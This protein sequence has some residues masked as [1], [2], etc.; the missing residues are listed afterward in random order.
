MTENFPDFTDC[1]RQA[2]RHLFTAERLSALLPV[3]LMLPVCL[4]LAACGDKPEKPAPPR[5]VRT[6]TV[7][8][9]SSAGAF[10]QT[11][12][13]RPHDEVTL[14]F[15]LDGRLL[16]RSVDVGDHVAAGQVLGSLENS[17]SQ[18][19]LDSARADLD[20][21]RAAEQLA[22]LNLRRMS[23]LIS[24]GAIARVQ[25]DTARSDWQAAT[26][27]R[28]SSEAALNT[29]RENLSW[30][31]LVAPAGGVVTQVSAEP[32]Q[33]VSAGQTVVTLAV[34]SG[35]DAVID[36]ADPQAFSHPAGGFRVSLLAAPSVSVTGTLRDISPQ[37]DAQTRTWRVRV[38]L[39]N[40]PTAMA[41][42]ASVQVGLAGTGPAVM[43]LP[44]S[45]LTRAQGRPAVFVVDS[46]TRRLHL[47]PVTLAG[48]TA[49]DILVSAG[50]R[51]GEPVVTAGVS[52]LREGEVVASGEAGE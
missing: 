47:R 49:S 44:A 30:T 6:V 8:A 37:A 48:F 45:A 32:G 27:R 36:V 19:Q 22:A 38:T 24:S 31:R 34:S 10:L 12:E 23:Q 15:R 25:L 16:T 52:K 18:N 51:P 5:P 40:P 4:L 33:V 14:G 7:P 41:L 2:L 46:A 39:D 42:G 50:V 17:T 20:S 13:I 21:A 28:R 1:V 3:V 9:P 29:A 35:R 43:R 11:G 26:S